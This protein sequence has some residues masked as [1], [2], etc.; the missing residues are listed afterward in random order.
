MLLATG[1]M[2]VSVRNAGGTRSH[3]RGAGIFQHCGG[4]DGDLVQLFSFYIWQ[5]LG[6][7]SR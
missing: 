5:R 6:R 1:T 2:I 4:S 7:G 3:Y